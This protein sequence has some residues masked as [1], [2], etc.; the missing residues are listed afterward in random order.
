MV[1]LNR[2][3]SLG[4]RQDRGILLASAIPSSTG[5][6]ERHKA[7]SGNSGMEGPLRTPS[8]S[9]VALI[10]FA[11]DLESSLAVG[12]GP[13]SDG[14]IDDLPVAKARQGLG[15][16][17]NLMSL[18]PDTNAVSSLH[19]ARVMRPGSPPSHGRKM[20]P[21]AESQRGA[22]IFVPA[23]TIPSATKHWGTFLIIREKSINPSTA[24]WVWLR[25]RL[26]CHPPGP[27][28]DE[29]GVTRLSHCP[30][31]PLQKRPQSCLEE[32]LSDPCEGE[33]L[34]HT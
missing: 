18:Q 4:G 2:G 3:H 9:P 29:G 21:G 32:D 5:I 7:P 31:I 15:T 11:S 1:E 12:G 34:P 20:L 16:L 24:V 22:V 23:T 10:S 14:A 19:E 28:G 26:Q 30:Q 25:K 6:T 27:S 13:A 8:T 17:N 33:L